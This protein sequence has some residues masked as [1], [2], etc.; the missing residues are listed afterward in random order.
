KLSQAP[1]QRGFFIAGGLMAD[2]TLG[3]IVTSIVQVM[4]RYNMTM[5]QFNA[6]L[7]GSGMVTLT[8]AAGGTRTVPCAANVL[9]ADGS[10][11]SGTWP[12]SVSGTA[13]SVKSLQPGQVQQALGYT[14]LRQDNIE[15]SRDDGG[16]VRLGTFNG[17]Q[18]GAK[19]ALTLLYSAGYNAANSQLGMATLLFSTSNSGSM[20]PGTGGAFYGAGVATSFGI[21]GVT[22]WIAQD[23]QTAYT[24]YAQLPNWSGAGSCN[25]WGDATNG[26][27]AARPGWRGGALPAGNFLAVQPQPL[28]TTSQFSSVPVPAPA[29][30]RT[31]TPTPGACAGATIY[32]T[33]ATGGATTAFS[34]GSAWISVRTGNPV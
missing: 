32:V 33:D 29:Y 5:D 30:T 7:T 6:W 10:N 27:W 20:Q 18:T 9:R 14:P 4:Q 23:S 11:A 17:P 19:L 1:R 15:D 28:L 21:G 31:T 3:D 24:V 2:P 13:G 12:I 26:G 16:F 22:F 8:D 34:N 25:A